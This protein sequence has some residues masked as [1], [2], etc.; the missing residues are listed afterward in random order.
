[1]GM[2]EPFSGGWM[3]FLTKPAWIREEMLDQA[4]SS[5]AVEFFFRTAILVPAIINGQYI[6]SFPK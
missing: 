4:T 6:H 3:S 2:L 1:M 5:A